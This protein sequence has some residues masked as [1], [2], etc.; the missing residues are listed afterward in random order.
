MEEKEEFQQKICTVCGT[1]VVETIY[2][3]SLI[4]GKYETKRYTERKVS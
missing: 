4:Y 2:P 3:S 1:L